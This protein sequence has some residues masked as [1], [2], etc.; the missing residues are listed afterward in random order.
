MLAVEGLQELKVEKFL[1]LFE[2][3]P[4]TLLVFEREELSKT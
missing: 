3:S 2:A 4:F 1:A